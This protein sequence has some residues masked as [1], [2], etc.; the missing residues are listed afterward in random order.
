[1]VRYTPL[2]HMMK[3]IHF[4]LTV[5]LIF[6]FFNKEIKSEPR[7]NII[8][9]CKRD[10]LFGEISYLYQIN[11]PKLSENSAF[12]CLE[13]AGYFDNKYF[14]FLIKTLPFKKNNDFLVTTLFIKNQTETNIQNLKNL[15]DVKKT[16]VVYLNWIF[17]ILLKRESNNFIEIFDEFYKTYHPNI[18]ENII[19]I[20]NNLKYKSYS[21]NPKSTPN[22]HKYKSLKDEEINNILIKECKDRIQQTTK[23][24]PDPDKP[25][26]SFTFCLEFLFLGDKENSYKIFKKLIESDLEIESQ[27]DLIT[28]I[29]RYKKKEDFVFFKKLFLEKTEKEFKKK[30]IYS[31]DGYDDEQYLIFL[32]NFKNENLLEM[33]E[34]KYLKERVNNRILFKNINSFEEILIENPDIVMSDNPSENL[35]NLLKLN[36]KYHRDILSLGYKYLLKKYPEKGYLNPYIATEI[37]NL[38]EIAIKTHMEQIKS[39]S[40]LT[41]LYLSKI[42]EIELKK[43]NYNNSLNN[44]TKILENKITAI[45]E[46]NSIYLMIEKLKFMV[47]FNGV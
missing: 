40:Y 21:E 43:F 23:F 29:S 22:N 35:L 15:L 45:I 5:S 36:Q 38:N 18:S 16:D 24:N 26:I 30:V 11:D 6:L 25:S 32:K 8:E 47:E 19:T 9:Y 33:N 42:A 13:L 39:D 17:E 28:I 10:Y 31:M 2:N 14:N 37:M 46:N 4:I 41:S 20:R 7:I 12:D 1:L 34:L 3:K 27:L 44:Y